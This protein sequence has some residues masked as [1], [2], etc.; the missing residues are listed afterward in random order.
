MNNYDVVIVGAGISGITLAERYANI[1]NFKV[2]IIDKREHIGGNC[3]DY[4]DNNGILVSKYGPHY[5]HTND[6]GVWKYVS[7][8]TKWNPYEHRVLG[9]VDGKIV[10]IPINM[11]TIN[12]LF[13]L[14]LETEDEVEKWLNK[15]REHID[16]PKNSE[17]VALSLIGR[18]LYEKIFKGYTTKQWDKQPSELDP[19]VIKRIPV[20]TDR[21]DR[22]FT[23]KYQAMPENGYTSM[24]NKMLDHKNITL[25]T[26][27]D[28][29]DVKNTVKYK[30]L[31]F[32]GKIDSYFEHK[33]GKL[34]Y[35]S[36][37]FEFETI[38]KEYFQRTAQENYPN[39][40]IPYT[41]I[42]EY[43]HATGQTNPYTVISKEYPTWEGE[44]YYPVPS[45]SNKQLYQKYQE[46]AERKSKDG[47]Y[48]VGRL[49]N[50]KYM[51]MDQAFRNSLN[52]FKNTKNLN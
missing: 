46:I 32:T 49:A 5:F 51:N 33:F 39:I 20:R 48:F 10:P 23:D 4:Y 7:L 27:T 35:R 26:G 50:Y 36:L 47:V 44:P 41:R 13:G 31:F 18:R 2:L 15:E 17:E 14:S 30:K 19:S 3:Y 45:E 52:I 8:F 16:D 28:W 1:K 21:D 29:S 12:I 11:D 37:K 34:E 42:V 24:F 6:E 38:K 43:K 40:D 25:R 22:Y 9:H